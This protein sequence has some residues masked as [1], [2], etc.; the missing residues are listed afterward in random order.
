MTPPE[1]LFILTPILI[2]GILSVEFIGK[3]RSNPSKPKVEHDNQHVFEE[4]FSRLRRDTEAR[5]ADIQHSFEDQHKRIP[6]LIKAHPTR[7]S[8]SQP[9]T[10]AVIQKEDEIDGTY[11][12]EREHDA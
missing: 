3:K 11:P 10:A 7:T 1:T 6:Y 4:T 8:T 5:R 9:K 2:I 12:A